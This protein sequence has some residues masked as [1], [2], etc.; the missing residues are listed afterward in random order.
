MPTPADALGRFLRAIYRRH[1]LLRAA[2]RAGLGLLAGCAAAAVLVPLLLWRGT[3]AVVP[4]LWTLG[5]ACSIGLILGVTRR[6]GPLEAAMEA[7]RQLLLADLL[8]T[9]LAVRA[10]GSA[11][12]WEAS[13]LGVA[14]ARCRELSPSAVLLHRLGARAWGGISLATALVLAVALLAGSPSETRAGGAAARRVHATASRAAVTESDRPLLPAG[15]GTSERAVWQGPGGDAGPD[16]PGSTGAETTQSPDSRGPAEGDPPPGGAASGDVS[17]G[18]PGS[19]STERRVPSRPPDSP[20]PRGTGAE[21]PKRTNGVATGGAG[22]TTGRGG[23]DSGSDVAAGTAAGASTAP[24]GSTPPW[25][26][27]GFDAGAARAR[28]ALEAGQVPAAYRDIVR[29]Y[30][31]RP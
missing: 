6:P 22:R 13:V 11:D 2:E 1:V 5:L 14:E 15:G 23:G 17:A 4:A 21:S 19:S 16:R 25:H 20:P 26:S 9:A 10:R 31:E 7:D 3:P 30:F 24:P 27:P 12:P 18:S 8:G 29:K 28:E